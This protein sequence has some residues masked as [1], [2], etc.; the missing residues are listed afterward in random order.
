MVDIS[1]P[2]ANPALS[3]ALERLHRE[4]TPANQD[5][6]LDEVVMR[7]HFLAPVVISPA[8]TDGSGGKT[9]L[10]QDAV[11]Q[12]QLI[13]AQDGRAFFPAFTDWPQLR[14]LCG[15]RDQQT[16]VLTF[17]DYASMLAGDA[18]AAGFVINPFGTPLTLERDFV[19][20]LSK[21]KKERA[22]Y[23]RQ[24]IGKD[25]KV[26]LGDPADYPQA[27]VDAIRLTARKV[28][29]IKELYLR[30]MSRPGQDRPSYLVVM[31]HSGDQ[32]RVFRAIADAARP[33]L[34][35]RFVDMVPFNSGFGQAAAKD[36][37]PFYSRAE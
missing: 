36:S 8:P 11:V 14:K 13:S 29:E 18:R 3:Q 20:H 1:K 22:G 2:I 33:H 12:F 23:S 31:D 15:P 10:K 7:A 37:A 28:P 17:D 35:G 9:T 16:V 27:M 5:R 34:E 32:D 4:N 24:I 6:V 25:T 26:L 30:L 21:Q 19:A